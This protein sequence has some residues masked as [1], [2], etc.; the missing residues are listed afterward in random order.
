MSQ[1]NLKKIQAKHRHET[2][3]V[4]YMHK[5]SNREMRRTLHFSELKKDTHTNSLWRLYH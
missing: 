1:K 5:G 2:I 4:K 3:A